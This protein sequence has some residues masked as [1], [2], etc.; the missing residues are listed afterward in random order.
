MKNYKANH[1]Y[2]IISISLYFVAIIFLL[3]L[4]LI[5]NSKIEIKKVDAAPDYIYS[6]VAIYTN[7]NTEQDA[8]DLVP[9]SISYYN[10]NISSNETN[11]NLRKISALESEQSCTILYFAIAYNWN[12]YTP[13]YADINLSNVITQMSKYNTS[14]RRFVRFD[15]DGQQ[16]VTQIEQLTNTPLFDFY[17][18][19]SI[20]WSCRGIALQAVWNDAQAITL[21]LDGGSGGDSAIHK[22]ATESLPVET[23]IT[24]PTKE[25]F[26]FLGYYS[27]ETQYITAEGAVVQN[28]G[29]WTSAPTT[30]V[31][32]WQAT[33]INLTLTL[34]C[35]N[36]Q[37]QHFLIYIFADNKI[38][39]Q[40]APAQSIATNLQLGAE[41]NSV[42]VQFVFSYNGSL[43]INTNNNITQEGRKVYLNEIKSTQ[44]D[45]SINIPNINNGI[46]I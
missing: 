27:G 19:G 5:A 40:I 42:Y 29:L 39:Q 8:M 46:V 2:G 36:F 9:M 37:N 41:T 23:T 25:G 14:T 10:G 38:M 34:N 24:P 4:A 7:F 12:G 21:S 20:W 18:N 22:F 3:S 16:N 11:D 28:A 13:D 26:V 44:I 45:Y 31:A 30:L 17:E 32:K 35:T 6:G 15:Y 43:S 1:F 33:N